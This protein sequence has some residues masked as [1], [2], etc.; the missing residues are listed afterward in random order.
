MA[1]NS[2]AVNRGPCALHRI[3]RGC[4][5]RLDAAD[6]LAA[7]CA[8]VLA[9]SADH[10]VVV[11]TTAARLHGLWLPPGMDDVH[12]ATMTPGVAG[13]SM[14]RTKRPQFHTH[15]W[16][17]AAGQTTVVRGVRVTT[18][19]RTWRDLAAYLDLPA[20]V[21]AGDSVL[22][23][24]TSIDELTQTVRQAGRGRHVRAVRTALPLLDKRSR[25]RPESHLRVAVSAPDL[26]RL[27]VNEP[28]SRRSGGWLAEP[29]LSLPEARL[30][31]EYQG[32]DHADPDRMRRD[33]TRMADL[34]AEGWLVL[35]Y[36]PAEVFSRPWEITG[37]VRAAIRQ[38]SPHLLKPADVRRPANLDRVAS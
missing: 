27:R 32:L 22:R 8:A 34:R 16:S 1:D 13:R 2:D 4:H 9:S 31:L 7:C 14:T 3:A 10:T 23:G 26:P 30:A 36:G 35:P 20:L 24:G 12:L 28:V 15:R 33:L 38:R 21:A 18:P 29:D 5:V 6:D 17:I 37:E 19:A 11:A 25:S